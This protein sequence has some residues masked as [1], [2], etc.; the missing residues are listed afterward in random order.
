MEEHLAAE[1]V[2][3]HT[4]PNRASLVT[5]RRRCQ[6]WATLQTKTRRPTRLRLPRTGRPRRAATVLFSIGAAPVQAPRHRGALV[7]RAGLGSLL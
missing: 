4:G 5:F 6:S 3:A 1:L 7:F 2:L